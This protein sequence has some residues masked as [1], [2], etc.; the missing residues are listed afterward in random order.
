MDAQNHLGLRYISPVEV[1]IKIEETFVA[2]L[3]ITH[4]GDV[5]HTIQILEVDVAIT[6]IV[7]EILVTTVEVVRDIG[8]IMITEG[9]IIVV[10]VMI[11]IEVDQQK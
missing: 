6:L 2:D 8:I 10:K 1:E 9:T 11:G 3:E 5:C 4:T 7:Q